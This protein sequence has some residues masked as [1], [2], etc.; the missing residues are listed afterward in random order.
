MAFGSSIPWFPAAQAL[1]FGL[2]DSSTDPSGLWLQGQSEKYPNSSLQLLP[3][4]LVCFLAVQL[5]R[6]ILPE[7]KSRISLFC[8]TT[9]LHISSPRL[10]H[11]VDC[12]TFLLPQ[13][14]SYLGVV[15]RNSCWAPWGAEGWNKGVGRRGASV[16]GQYMWLCQA[17]RGGAWAPA[18]SELRSGSPG[19][20]SEGERARSSWGHRG[21]V[22]PFSHCSCLKLGWE[23]ARSG[24]CCLIVPSLPW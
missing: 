10:C 14:S 13:K 8:M 15:L 7:M 21:T 17:Q 12:K 4:P 19:L 3:V 5:C 6:L 20:C 11:V 9:N 1:T 16:C 23:R 18:S 2:A 24:F 22:K